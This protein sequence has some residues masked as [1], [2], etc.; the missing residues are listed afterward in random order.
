MER[1]VA[2]EKVLRD[3]SND[4]KGIVGV[5]KNRTWKV[6]HKRVQKQRLMG[7]MKD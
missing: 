7:G 3:S 4:Y 1:P 5:L 6:V 2:A